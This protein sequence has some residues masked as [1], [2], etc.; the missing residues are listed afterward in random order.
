MG[1]SMVTHG[2]LLM[3]TLHQSIDPEDFCR[4]SC[5]DSYLVLQPSPLQNALDILSETRIEPMTYK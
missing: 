3:K 4:P 2:F 5:Y 1:K